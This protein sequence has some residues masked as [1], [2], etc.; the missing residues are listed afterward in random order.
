MLIHEE[1]SFFTVKVDEQTTENIELRKVD[2]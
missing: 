1:H 2:Y